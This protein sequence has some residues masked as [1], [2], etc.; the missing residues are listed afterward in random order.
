MPRQWSAHATCGHRNPVALAYVCCLEC[1]RKLA[2]SLDL[3]RLIGREGQVRDRTGNALITHS[4]VSAVLL[5][6]SICTLLL[7]NSDRALAQGSEISAAQH[8]PMAF[9]TAET[10]P[11]LVVG[12]VGG[13]VRSNDARHSEVQLVQDLRR[14]HR[15][16]VRILLFKHGERSEAHKTILAWLKGLLPGLKTDQERPEPRIILF[17]HSW[18]ASAVVYL[19]RELEEE[20]IP[21]SLTIQVDSVRK[22]G[23]DDSVVPAN[24][25]EAINFYQ[26][27]G[28]IHGRSKIT[29]AD[30][31][32]TLVLGNF[33]FEYEKQPAEC[34]VYP[35]YDRLLFKGHISIECDPR[36]WSQ[37]ETLIDARLTA[38]HP[39][40]TEVRAQFAQQISSH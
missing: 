9:T 25:S 38:A 13:F 36:V 39:A 2:V 5:L 26:T 19:A 32:R 34:H 14:K 16:G 18:G 22:N 24:V 7:I 6:V 35:W 31:T 40:L 1:A 15:D 17:G 4:P 28:I 12:F 3:E 30:P 20:A 8:G 11:T 29:A 23:E 37:V 33:R 27:K 21:V 10:T